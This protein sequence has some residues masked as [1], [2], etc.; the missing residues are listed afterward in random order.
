M[1]IMRA[2]K[3]GSIS[4][5]RQN[6]YIEAATSDNTRRAYRSDI[7]H[8]KAWGGILPANTQ[9]IIEYL[10]D[11]ASSLNPRTL[12]RRLV[13]IRNWHIYL[14]HFD[15][16][17]DPLVKKTI[18]GIQNVHGRPKNK[19]PG[20]TLENLKKIVLY[21]GAQNTTRACRDNA[22]LQV[23]FFGAFRRSELV[24]ILYENIKMVE[25]G[26]EIILP[27]SKADQAR[28]GTICALPYG[29]DILCPVKALKKW[30]NKSEIRNGYIFPRSWHITK[31]KGH[32]DVF[33]VNK[34]LKTHGKACNILYAESFSGHSLRR[35]LATV[36]S[37]NGA[38]I[39]SIMR[40]GR[41]NHHA[42]V[43]E[44]IEEGERFAENAVNTILFK[45]KM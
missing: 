15:P 20:L 30:L 22:L 44:Y 11:Y 37:Q 10:H 5:E 29:D 38:T 26:I 1:T 34:A 36:A 23:G 12:H 19:A 45:N 24:S 31:P 18:A 40:Q 21:L 25:K 35:G 41:W 13:A 17:S 14:G 4:A 9:I 3:T 6:L 7:R 32:I 42:T 43:L 39:A 33:T 28:E 16:T 2:E 27:K 8:F